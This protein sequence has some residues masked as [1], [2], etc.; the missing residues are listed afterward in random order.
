M[1]QNVKFISIILLVFSTSLSSISQDL[2]KARNRPMPDVVEEYF[3][4]KS[5]P[6][7]KEG[8]YKLKIDNTVYLIGSYSNNQRSGT[9]QIFRSENEIAFKYNYDTKQI[10]CINQNLN[11]D[12]K[13]PTSHVA[14]Y[15]GGDHYFLCQIGNQAMLPNGL[16]K[17][18]TSGR[19][20]ST[21]TFSIDPQGHPIDFKILKS[22][23]VPELDAK[24]IQFVKSIATS[25]LG[26]IPGQLKGKY[27]D[28]PWM[29]PVNFVF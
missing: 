7:I 12:P 11:L 18:M 26:F 20:N 9:W 29:V 21:V 17:I 19:Y 3:V 1:K 15:L 6:N 27:V 22:S 16:E 28:M 23:N 25:D 14:L 24:A 4:L 13:D 10:T 5:D 8:P 2:K